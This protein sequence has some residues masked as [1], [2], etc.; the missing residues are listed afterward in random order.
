MAFA[1]TAA[2]ESSWWIR[3]ESSIDAAEQVIVDC[4][5]IPCAVGAYL[6]FQVFLAK[7]VLTEEQR[8]YA[9]KTGT[10]FSG[11]GPLR[12]VAWISRSNT[13]LPVSPV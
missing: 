1:T 13:S 11:P 5:P 8:P 9:A 2:F 6:S 12:A 10:C 3:N 7:G 4:A